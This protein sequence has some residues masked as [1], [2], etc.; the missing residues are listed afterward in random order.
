MSQMRLWGVAVVA[1]LLA[2]AGT[3]RAE[4]STADWEALK[5][6][7]ADV[8]KENAEIRK[9]ND[10]L[11]GTLGPI[12]DSVA[13]MLDNKFGPGAE[14]TSRQGRL[15]INGLVQIYYTQIQQDK[16]GLFYDDQVNNIQDNNEGQDCSGFRVRRTELRFTLDINDYITAEVMIEPARENQSYPA[17][18]DNQAMSCIFKRLA[19]QQNIANIQSGAASAGR[20][21]QN[22]FVQYHDYIP[23]HDFKIGQFKPPLGEEVT[24]SNAQLDFAERSFVGQLGDFRDQGLSAH[25]SWWDDAKDG[26]FQYWLGVF[27]GPGNYL[28]SGG[29]FQNRSDD[30]SDK[31]FIYRVLLRPL[32]KDKTYGSI[33]FGMSSEM[34][35]HGGEGSTDPVDNPVNGLNRLSNWAIRHDG[36]FQYYPGGPVRGLWFK[37]EYGW[38]KDRNAPNSVIDVLNND[39]AGVG[40]QAYGKPFSVQ[41][42]YAAA[43]YKIMDSRWAEE[44]PHWAKGFEILGRYDEFQNVEV[45]DLVR[46]DHTDVFR[47]QVWTAGLNYFFK[48]NNAKIQLNYNTVINPVSHNPNLVFH[49]VKNDNLVVN[50][51]VWW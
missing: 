8:R 16:K 33:E 35:R 41:G 34:G 26:R 24:R 45:A 48:G 14:A 23:H 5:K 21:L 30:N 38:Y 1:S 27:N 17:S 28:D 50:F 31:D 47:T 15:S 40:V 18:P 43:G 9:A 44:A 19:G 42:G 39:I 11:T 20:L 22:A 37:G 36:W 29:Q 4:I 25:G 13:K 49:D 10:Q 46:P 7:I 2:A 3:A 32:W 51:Q 6:E 12:K